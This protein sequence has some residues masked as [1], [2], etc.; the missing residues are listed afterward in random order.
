[1]TLRALFLVTS[2]LLALPAIWCVYHLTRQG[3]AV[4][5]VPVLGFVL[6]PGYALI[7]RNCFRHAAEKG[8]LLRDV[9]FT[10]T[11]ILIPAAIGYYLFIQ[12]PALI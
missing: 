10:Y 9:V 3:F 4:W 6:W 1:M 11:L 12:L 7:R 5:P 2:G 8:T